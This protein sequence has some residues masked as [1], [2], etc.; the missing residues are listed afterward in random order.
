MAPGS[1][2][3]RTPGEDE[4]KYHHL[5]LLARNE[6]GYRNLLRLVSAAH[7][8]GFY[9]RPRMDKQLMAEH[10]EG[11]ICLSGCL[12]SEVSVGAAARAGPA[13]PRRRRRVPRHLRSRALLHRAA[14]PRPRRPARDP[15]PADRAR[16]RARHPARRDE[17]PALHAEGG[18]QAPRRAPVHPAEEAADRPEAAEVRQRRVLPEERGGDARGLLRAARGLRRHAGH[19]RAR[20]ARPGVRGPGA[21]RPALPPAAVRDARRDRARVLPP[22]ARGRGRACPLRAGPAAGGAR[23]DRARAERHHLHG[24]RRLL[25]DRVGPDPPRAGAGHPRRSRARERRRLRRLVL[26]AHHRPGS[27]ALRPA[28]RA[29][30]EP[31]AD[32]DAGHRHGL[33]RAPPGRGDP[34]RDRALRRRSRRA[35]HHVPDD[36][37]QA[38]D[39]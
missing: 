34:V 24:V 8:E 23:P 27:A 26:A 15:P 10:A 13:G 14:G 28:V 12:S 35:D 25:P 5:T 21:D 32:P 38:G 6:T 16:A 29:V 30:P 4:Q 37:G 31:R 3:D 20:G 18:R 36:Q 9:H 17:R 39:P 11:I 7:L 1:R 2:F 33:R 19:R 22:P